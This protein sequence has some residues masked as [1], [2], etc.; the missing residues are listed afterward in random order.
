MPSVIEDFNQQL[1]ENRAKTVVQ[2]LV[3][4]GVESD[5]LKAVGYGESQPIA[6]NNSITGRKLKTEE[7][8]H[9]S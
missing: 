3:Q 2:Y 9:V 1:S 7:Q 4:Q 6:D 5:R 8:R